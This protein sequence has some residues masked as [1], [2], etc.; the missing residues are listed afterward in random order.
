MQWFYDLNGDGQWDTIRLDRRNDGVADVEC[1]DAEWNGV[2]E[3]CD[4]DL[5]NDGVNDLLAADTNQSGVIE[6]VML[7]SNYDGYWDLSL[8]DLNGNGPS[9]IARRRASPKAARCSS[10]DRR[11]SP[12]GSTR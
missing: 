6:S 9:R 4:L 3:R 1:L 7:D 2:L 11:P 10:W 5:N 8:V 12:A